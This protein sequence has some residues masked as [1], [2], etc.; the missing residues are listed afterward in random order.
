V[1]IV[2]LHARGAPPKS[3]RDIRLF[4][5]NPMRAPINKL[6]RGGLGCYHGVK[7]QIY[8]SRIIEKKRG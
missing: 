6:P 8:G 1:P 4:A 2:E 5:I 3:L 7:N